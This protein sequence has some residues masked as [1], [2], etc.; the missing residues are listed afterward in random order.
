MARRSLA[1]KDSDLIEAAEKPRESR[2]PQRPA[3]PSRLLI[4]YFGG[5]EVFVCL[6]LHLPHQTRKVVPAGNDFRM[7]LTERFFLVLLA[8]WSKLPRQAPTCG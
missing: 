2:N 7:R 5:R 8:R 1:S 4:A 3:V 6:P